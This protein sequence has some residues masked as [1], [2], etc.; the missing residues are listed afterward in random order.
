MLYASYGTCF[1]ALKNMA[2]AEKYF[3]KMVK[4]FEASYTNKLYRTNSNIYIQCYRTIGKFYIDTK[5]FGK[6]KYYLQKL[7]VVP[8]QFLEPAQV[9]L[10]QYS[11]FRTDSA[12]CNFLSAIDHFKQ[13]LVVHDSIFNAKKAHQMSELDIKYE[14]RQRLQSIKLLNSEKN[15][16]RNEL[17]RINMQRNMYSAVLSYCCF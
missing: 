1:S 4:V 9:E 12:A 8:S 16:Q 10:L 6:A 5:E 11:L 2:E 3:L 13:S 17:K 14:T 7:L 15:E